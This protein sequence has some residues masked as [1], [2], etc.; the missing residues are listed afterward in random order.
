MAVKL[1]V[2]KLNP[3]PPDPAAYIRDLAYRLIGTDRGRDH[4]M[5]HPCAELGGKTPEELINDGRADVVER[6][7]AAALEG[8]FG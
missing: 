8:E 5:T 1:A 4:W 2:K 6:Y 3:P 7:L